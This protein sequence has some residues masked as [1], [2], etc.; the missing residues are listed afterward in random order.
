MESAKDVA[1]VKRIEALFATLDSEV[2]KAKEVNMKDLLGKRWD[3][4][5]ETMADTLK[6]IVKKSPNA[7][8]LLM[9]AVQKHPKLVPYARE[10]EKQLFSK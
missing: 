10:V 5:T 3:G 2:K 7:Y 4:G 8:N 9:V 1:L 6:S